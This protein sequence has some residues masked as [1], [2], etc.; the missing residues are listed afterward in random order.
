MFDVIFVI[1][2]IISRKLSHPSIV[3]YLGIYVQG[4]EFYIVME[5]MN[6]GNLHYLLQSSTQFTETDLLTM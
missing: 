6:A 2:L 1:I 4:K 5:L 3:Q